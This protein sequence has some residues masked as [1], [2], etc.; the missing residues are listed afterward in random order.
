MKN[1]TIE[2]TD[3][4]FNIAEGCVKVSEG[5]KN[6]YAEAR[7]KRWANDNWGV[8][9][10]RMMRSENYWHQPIAWDAD[11][12]AKGIK[13]KVFC[14]S[15]CDVFEQHDDLVAPRFRLFE[16]MASTPHLIWQLL[17]KRPE[18]I[19]NEIA[20]AYKHFVHAEAHKIAVALWIQD[21][22]NGDVPD[23]VWIGTTVEN[24][25]A[26]DSRL[27]WLLN[28][29]AKVRFLSCEPLIGAVDLAKNSYIEGVDWVIVGGES[30][31]NARPMNPLWVKGI[32][33]ACELHDVPFFFKQWGEFAPAVVPANYSGDNL[34]V[35]CN[36]TGAYRKYT[37]LVLYTGGERVMAKVGKGKAGRALDGREY[38]F[39]PVG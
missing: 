27:P 35:S 28:V 22:L 39:F 14:S 26:F 4:T 31:R 7:N 24:Q 17:T 20:N 19:R 8:G 3:H 16:L 32:K 5:C 1:S 37:N 6:C 30:G 21:W 11:A 9:S 38:S 33:E 18:N 12:A 13:Y 36:I 23:N 29:P 2:W 25:K 15:L 10:R 34:Y